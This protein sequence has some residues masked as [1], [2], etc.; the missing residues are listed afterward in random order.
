[1]A[2]KASSVEPTMH[3]A[4][5]LTLGGF[6]TMLAPPPPKMLDI[7]LKCICVQ[8]TLGSCVACV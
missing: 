2:L 1:M 3:L 4:L 8:L 6:T 7:K 5:S